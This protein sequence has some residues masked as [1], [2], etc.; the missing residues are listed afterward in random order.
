MP[1]SISPEFERNSGGKKS[2][3]KLKVPRFQKMFAHLLENKTY[4]KLPLISDVFI[5][6]NVFIDIT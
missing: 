2:S 3:K 4:N 5:R 6:E 1:N